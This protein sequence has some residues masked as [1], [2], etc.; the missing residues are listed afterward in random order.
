MKTNYIIYN[1]IK[2]KY[3]IIKKGTLMFR[4]IV[5]HESLSKKHKN[6]F[7]KEFNDKNISYN[8]LRDYFG[9]QEKKENYCLSPYYNLFLYFNPFFADTNLWL[10]NTYERNV[11]IYEIQSDL[12]L[13]S[14]IDTKYKI[15]D[16]LFIENDILVKCN[17]I[18]LCNYTGVKSDYCLSMNFMK[19]HPDIIGVYNIIEVDNKHYEDKEHLKIIKPFVKYIHREKM[20]PNYYGVPQIYIYPLKNRLFNEIITEYNVLSKTYI[21]KLYKYISDNYDNY[22]L[23]LIDFIEHQPFKIDKLMSFIKNKCIYKNGRF[24]LK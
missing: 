1:G 2:L 13:L 7:S 17:T 6:N 16:P 19:T 4:T 22:N 5:G 8:I 12:K 11:A 14:F 3:A 18:K 9:K 20:N 15:D 24:R 10:N 23:F 21:E